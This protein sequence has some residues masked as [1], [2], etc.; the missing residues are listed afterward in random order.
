MSW[1]GRLRQDAKSWPGRPISEVWVRTWCPGQDVLT[2]TSEMG[3]PG[4]STIGHNSKKGVICPSLRVTSDKVKIGVDSKLDSDSSRNL[5]SLIE[6]YWI[7]ANSLCTTHNVPVPCLYQVRNNYKVKYES[8][9]WQPVVG[10]NG[11]PVPSKIAL[12]GIFISL[13]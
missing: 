11:L 7:V 10:H 6:F 2:Q 12:W 3:R 13:S 8:F 5:L 1:P 9:G 4:R